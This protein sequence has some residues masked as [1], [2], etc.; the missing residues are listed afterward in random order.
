LNKG[1]KGV[2]QVKNRNGIKDVHLLP[3]RLG[4]CQKNLA[5]VLARLAGRN[6]LV[7]SFVTC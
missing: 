1:F 5:Q 3:G 6:I 7:V 2:D 4:V